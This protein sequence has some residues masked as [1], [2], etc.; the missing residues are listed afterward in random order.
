M[1]DCEIVKSKSCD[2]SLFVCERAQDA[3]PWLHSHCVAEIVEVQSVGCDGWQV[4]VRNTR[5][6]VLVDKI[7]VCIQGGTG[8][9][10]QFVVSKGAA[11]GV[12]TCACI[13]RVVALCGI[14]K[15]DDDVVSR[16]R[17]YFVVE[18]TNCSIEGGHS[19]I[20]Y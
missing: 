8:Q 19:G 7:P 15:D 4:L 17:L 20:Q 13:V 9:Q 6:A 3:D 1:S 18:L 14:C 10:C 11:N 5:K 16:E 2:M 12:L